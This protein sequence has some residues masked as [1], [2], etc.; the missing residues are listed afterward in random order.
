MDRNR[1]TPKFPNKVAKTSFCGTYGSLFVKLLSETS[2]VL[3]CKRHFF[4]K[5]SKMIVDSGA[6]SVCHKML[7]K[8]PVLQ[9][10]MHSIFVSNTANAPQGVSK[11][12]KSEFW[13]FEA[14]IF[15]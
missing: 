9:C 7:Q 5:L 11:D 2:F 6:I 10:Q 3:S 14:L 1:R 4:I 8:L 12:Q 13:Q 15:S